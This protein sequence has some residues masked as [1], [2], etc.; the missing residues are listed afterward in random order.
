MQTSVRQRRTTHSTNYRSA[1]RP[2]PRRDRAPVDAR[3]A[4]ELIETFRIPNGH[5][6]S[7]RPIQPEDADALRRAF[8]RL[9]PEQVR[10]RLF[11]RVN[12]LSREAAGQLTTIDPSTTI[13]YVVVDAEGEI[14]AE[15]RIHIDAVTDSAE[16][17]VAV[18]PS[19]TNHGIGRRLMERLIEDARRRGLYELWGDV[20]AEN[21]TMLDFMKRLGAER[22]A[23][24]DE[25]GLTRVHIQLGESRSTSRTA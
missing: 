24:P 1:T 19:F 6:L 22:R 17:A 5:T 25:P 21:H 4:A 12:E 15:A 16:F 13:A 14:R 11:H 9:T 23:V 10:L 7:L 8:A 18:D 20:M 2:P 3:P